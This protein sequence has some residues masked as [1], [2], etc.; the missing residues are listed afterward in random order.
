MLLRPLFK[1]VCALF[2]LVPAQAEV[3]VEPYQATLVPGATCAFK[4]PHGANWRWS[5]V[6]GPG[7]IDA[8]T[9]VYLAPPLQDAATARVR[10]TLEADPAIWGEAA[11]ALLPLPAK[12]FD[13]V[14]QVLGHGWVVPFSAGLPFLDPET[15]ERM[16]AEAIHDSAWVRGP[17]IWA[18]Y[19][20]P[21]T[22]RWEPVPGAQALLS[23][24][25]GGEAVRRDVTGQASQVIVPRGQIAQCRVEALFRGPSGG[26]SSRVQ[27]TQVDVRGLFPFAGNPV[28][29][30]GHQDGVGLAARFAQP[31]GLARLPTVAGAGVALLVTD[32]RNHLVRTVTLDGQAATLC[33]E[34]GTAGH[35]DSPSWCQKLRSAEDWEP[36]PGPLF[37]SPTY[38]AVRT[39]L[40]PGHPW[41]AI[42]ADSG[43]HALRLL[44]PD[45]TVS[46]L[47]GTPRRPGYLDSQDPALAAFKD[48]RGLAVDPDDGSLYVADRGN[49]VLRIVHSDG[50][51]ATLAGHPRCPGSRDGVGVQAGFTDLKGLC[52]HRMAD[53]QKV[54]FV[55]DGHALRRVTLPGGAVTTLLGVVDRPGWREIRADDGPDAARQPCLNDPTG[56]LPFV[57]GLFIADH[58][59][60][61]V[62][63]AT[64]QNTLFTK[65]GSPGLGGRS[66]WGLL[67]DRLKAPLFEAYG[68]LDG[69]WTLA[70]GLHA[71]SATPLVVTTG[72][73]L[74]TIQ[75]TGEGV[76]DLAIAEPRAFQTG[77]DAA[78]TISF[79]TQ[80]TDPAVP[81]V[82]RDLHYTVDFLDAE[83]GLGARVQ[84]RGV[85]GHRQEVR[86]E[87]A[88]IDVASV[89]IR[90]VTDQGW[91]IGGQFW[92]VPGEPGLVSAAPPAGQ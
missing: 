18:G 19:G 39:G 91:S 20:I 12:P 2:A 69:P 42:V 79:T 57:G 70:Y 44:R 41:E 25:E 45:G 30:A 72:P 14:T 89:I 83:G 32:P 56:L 51:V 15:G 11:I 86:A 67:P 75:H 81:L 37:D 13:L 7:A 55:L 46:T 40:G 78:L 5:M 34:P 68:A 62:R 80:P 23:Y 4:A 9:G 43:N 60:H 88:W 26:W 10:A 31:F 53:Q 76:D 61:A 85:S 21:F 64:F 66:H 16:T 38:L 54:L 47:A 74:G 22:L 3:Q 73:C 90:C 33:G 63:V 82:H 24:R 36:A 87:P 77:K 6:A 52:V 29:G 1:P 58:G 92:V 50:R 84:G 65:A 49:R 8:R 17:R 28:A 27:A 71:G 35:R 59:N 48:P